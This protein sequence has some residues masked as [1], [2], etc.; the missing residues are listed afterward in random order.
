MARGLAVWLLIMLA[1]TA[2]GILRGLFLVP[3]VGEVVAGRI[4]W[5]IGLVIV[6]G[7][8]I[9]CARW[10]GLKE[11]RALLGLGLIWMVLTFCFEIAIGFARGLSNAA[12]FAEIN[13]LAGGLMVYSLVVMLFA[14]LIATRLRSY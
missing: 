11:R 5:P 2:H 4:G 12:M 9:L 13:P 1:E 6:L 8:A 7:I 10:V 3:R 14:P